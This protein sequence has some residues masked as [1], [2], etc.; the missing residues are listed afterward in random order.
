MMRP[1][2]LTTEDDPSVVELRRKLDVFYASTKDYSDF[3]VEANSKPE[4]WTPIKAAIEQRLADKGSCR[5]LEFGA[6]RTGFAVFLRELRSRVRF[7]VQDVTPQNQ[8]YL[9]GEA[10]AVHIGDI[11]GL[12][13]DY[14]IMFST[15][16]WEHGTNPRHTRD[17][18]LQ[19]LSPG[20]SLFVACPRYDMPGY[21]PPSARH[22]TTGARLGLTL[23]QTARWLGL[24]GRGEQFLIHTDP[25]LL[26]R[27]WF[28]DSDAIHWV[29]MQDF[30]SIPRGFRFSRILIPAP[31][32]RG[33]IW[34]RFLV[35]FV[36]ITREDRA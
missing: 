17:L 2:F 27:P 11:S 36:Q 34:S 35:A 10:D 26:H 20:G 25:A 31:G 5:I 4:I 3:N 29:S 1:A 32:L 21:I 8:D 9:S 28:R 12:A 22:Y 18:L 19:R 6:G 7:E 13:G 16:V 30:A 24:S 23:W 14:D 33:F 15:F